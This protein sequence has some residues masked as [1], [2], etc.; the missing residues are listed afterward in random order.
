MKRFG[1]SWSS[2]S[3]GFYAVI[4]FNRPSVPMIFITRFKL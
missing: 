3:W 1:T 4:A 2:K